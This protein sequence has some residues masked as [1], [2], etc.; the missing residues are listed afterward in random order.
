MGGRYYC[1]AKKVNYN[2]SPWNFCEYTNNRLK[3]IYYI[4]KCLIKYDHVEFGRISYPD[5]RRKLS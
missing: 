1:M 3:W 4:V 5:K 2:K